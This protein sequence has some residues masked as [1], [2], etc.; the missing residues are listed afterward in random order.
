MGL[1]Q[2]EADFL[3]GLEKYSQ[4]ENEHD[5]ARS[6]LTIPLRS[7]DHREEFLLDMSRGRIQITKM[8]YQMRARKAVILARL[9]LRGSPHRNPDGEEIACPHLHVFREGFGDKW[10]QPLPKKHFSNHSEARQMFDEFLDFCT[11]V[12]KPNVNFG[13][14]F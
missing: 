1:T 13:L 12:E 9:D 10:A 4:D 11:V 8:K 5:F 7:D 6:R 14:I 2:D 3:L